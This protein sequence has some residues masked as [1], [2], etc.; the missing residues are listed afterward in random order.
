M[1]RPDVDQTDRALT[2]DSH[3]TGVTVELF[4][5]YSDFS[6]GLRSSEVRLTFDAL[7]EFKESVKC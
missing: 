5:S 4:V 3:V 1:T 6:P 7:R 2:F